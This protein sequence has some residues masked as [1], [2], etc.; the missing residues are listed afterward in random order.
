MPSEERINRREQNIPVTFLPTKAQWRF[1]NV[2]LA[3]DGPVTISGCARTASINRRTVYDWFEDERFRL[4]FYSECDKQAKTER[5]LMWRNARR[6]AIA[7]S[8]EHIK[9]VAAKAG[10]L[11]GAGSNDHM[12]AGPTAVFIN[13][14]R[15][16]AVE[17]DAVEQLQAAPVDAA[18]VTDVVTDDTHIS[19]S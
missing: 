18:V 10:E 6:L 15:P 19:H 4:W 3:P 9:L 17:A 7:G 8:P 2:F 14:P 11:I 5:E 13:V 16:K 12:R 1:L